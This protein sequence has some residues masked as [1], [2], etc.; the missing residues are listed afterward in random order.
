MNAA[1]VYADQGLEIVGVHM[2]EYAEQFDAFIAHHKIVWPESI[3]RE[4]NTAKAWKANYPAYY[5]IDRTGT[6]RFAD[7][8]RQH[9]DAAIE[10]LLREP[11]PKDVPSEDDE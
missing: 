6:L 4:E 2:T 10:E 5:L 9:L 7:L 1:D 3:D 8:Y 11:P